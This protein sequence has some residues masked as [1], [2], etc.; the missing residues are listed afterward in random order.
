VPKYALLTRHGPYI[1]EPRDRTS[2]IVRKVRNETV[3]RKTRDL[4]VAGKKGTADPIGESRSLG[5]IHKIAP[6]DKIA[7]SLKIDGPGSRIGQG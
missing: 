3:S 4:V 2:T 5:I 6:F 1:V 7:A